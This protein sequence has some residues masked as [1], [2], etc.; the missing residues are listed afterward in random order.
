MKKLL[1]LL[2]L[3]LVA[4]GKAED[5]APTPAAPYFSDRELECI[6]YLETRV[7]GDIYDLA[8]YR[9]CLYEISEYSNYDGSITLLTSTTRYNEDGYWDYYITM[10]IEQSDGRIS[11]IYKTVD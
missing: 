2:L 6:D 9:D 11:H 3:V 5:N 1:W 10:H 7:V 4:C 8:T